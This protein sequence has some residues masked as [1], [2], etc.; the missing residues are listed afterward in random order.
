MQ[1]WLALKVQ[2]ASMTNSLYI[3]L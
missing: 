2:A 1:H 3:V